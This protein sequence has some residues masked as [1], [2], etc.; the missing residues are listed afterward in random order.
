MGFWAKAKGVFNRIING[1]KSL[2]RKIYDNKDK[3]REAVEPFVPDKY[4]PYIDRGEHM[5]DNMQRL[6]R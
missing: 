6:I 1:G 2:V 4:K 5:V 3:I